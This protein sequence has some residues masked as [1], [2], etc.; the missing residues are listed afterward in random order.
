[1]RRKWPVEQF[2]VN[3][4]YWYALLVPKV[5]NP[6][7][8]QNFITTFCSICGESKAVGDICMCLFVKSPR[9]GAFYSY[10][11]NVEPFKSKNSFDILQINI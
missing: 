5:G 11:E 9:D 8:T 7:W 3:G 10:H 2:P 4:T 1:M 6:N